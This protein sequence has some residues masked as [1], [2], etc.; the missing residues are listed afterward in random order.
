MISKIQGTAFM[1][2]R[3]LRTRMTLKDLRLTEPGNKSKTLIYYIKK[4][5]NV[6][7]Q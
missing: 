3:G 6:I 4:G 5:G 1:L 7:T 2:L